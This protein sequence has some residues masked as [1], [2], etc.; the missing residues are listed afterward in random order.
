MSQSWGSG[1][2]PSAG[3]RESLAITWAQSR[4]APALA[5]A[6]VAWK[7]IQFAYRRQHWVRLLGHQDVGSADTLV[8]E[9]G[10]TGLPFV[11]VANGCATA[12]SALSVAAH[13]IGAG[14]VRPRPRRRLRQASSWSLQRRSRRPSACRHWYG[15]AGFMVTTQFFA[16]KINRYM[17][18]HDIT[19]NTLAKVA[20]K[21]YRNGA[22][23][24]NA[25]R[26][27]PFTEEEILE[28]TMLN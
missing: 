5:D 25:W 27:K 1:S 11:N 4:C 17:H 16:M 22:L 26:R 24:P 15:E 20:A 13:T 7:D 3:S 6:G 21:A 10:M 14:R 19:Q 9:L 2:T 23:N 8:N 18:E 28:S 12:G